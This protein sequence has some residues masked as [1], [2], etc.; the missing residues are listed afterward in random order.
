LN[1]HRFKILFWIVGLAIMVSSPH[2]SLAQSPFSSWEHP[3]YDEWNTGFSPQTTI[4]RENVDLLELKW[5]YHFRDSPELF[6]AVPPEGIQTTP[7]IFQGI[8]YIASG[9]NELLAIEAST[10][11]ELWSFRPDLASYGDASFWPKRLATR[12]LSIHSGSIYMQTSECSIYGFGLTTGE[13]NFLLPR[14]CDQIPGNSG[15]YFA[16]FAPTFFDNL[17][18]TRAQ[19]NAFGGR[20]FVSAYDLT[21]KELVW[22][23][24]SVPPEGGDPNWGIS[25]ADKGNIAP[26]KG[27]W[28][29]S[30]L[31][32]GGTSWGLIAI[33]S[34]AG[35]IFL[36]TGEPANQ[37]DA[38]LRP[39]PNL[40]SNSIVALDART[41]E[42]VWYYQVGPHDINNHDP[43]WKVILAQIDQGGVDRKV[44][45]SATKS[46]FVYV[47]D[48]E[49]GE[50]VFEPTHIGPPN[51][52]TINQNPENEP[53]LR[54]SQ[55]RYLGDIFCPSQLGGV[56]SGPAF[57]YNTIF[58]P[59]QN[60]CG[61]VIEERLQYKGK[62]IDGFR[63]LLVQD[64]PGNGSI[65]AIDASNGEIKWELSIPNRL[66][67][68]SLI[69]SGNVVYAIDRAGVFYAIDSDD[70]TI[71][72]DMP[73]NA[74]GSAGPAIGADAR[75]NTLLLIAV[76]GSELTGKKSGVLIALGLPEGTDSSPPLDLRDL[77][78]IA[79]LTVAT[80]SVA[81]AVISRRR[82]RSMKTRPK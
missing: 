5:I 41:G 43:G 53:D 2:R 74:L 39:G 49:T 80:F 46:N 38:A 9:Y 65:T 71:L 64:S 82:H 55:R 40:F 35:K 17:L 52:N 36:L 69:V 30:D 4:T 24:L 34:E 62:V 79:A 63:Y 6:G 75:G 25:E 8:V 14:T 37:F 44:V 67:S 15:L 19:G 1:I 72:R 45:I 70:G 59:S 27:D 10:G 68:A 42:M 66:Q 31:I 3:A 73:L 16:T 47:L 28:G 56:F 58:V 23:W 29:D 61:T 81:Y 13:V 50:P 57:G 33:D 12:S 32:G 76:G 7:L 21:T 77:I 18:I 26:F 54:A 78:S 22:Q 60:T 20:G 51:F 11:K 48:A